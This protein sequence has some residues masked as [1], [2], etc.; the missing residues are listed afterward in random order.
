MKKLKVQLRL[1][2]IQQGLPGTAIMEEF[3]DKAKFPESLTAQQRKDVLEAWD[4][5]Y[6]VPKEKKEYADRVQPEE[7]LDGEEYEKRYVELIYYYLQ[8]I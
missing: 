7:K 2:G 4:T 1:L 8:T 3:I 6:E 5:R